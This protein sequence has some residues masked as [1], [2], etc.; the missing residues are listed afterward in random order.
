MSSQPVYK[1]L[2]IF[3]LAVVWLWLERWRMQLG[4]AWED[5]YHHWLLAAHIART[6]MA[7]DP[8]TGNSN[9]WLP[10]YHWTGAGVLSLFGW[11]NLEALGGFSAFLTLLTAAL[12]AWKRGNVWAALFLFNPVTVLNGS[13]S[14]VEPLA[15]LLAVAGVILWEAEIAW[16]AALCWALVALCDRGSWPEVAV[17][18]LWFLPKPIA[19]LPMLALALGYGLTHQEV[20]TTAVWAAVDQ[21]GL[22]TISER[23]ANLLNFSWK[24]LAIALGL[25]GLGLWKRPDLRTATLVCAGLTAVFVLVSA[26]NLTGSSRYYLLPIALLAF[27][28]GGGRPWVGWLLLPCLGFFSVQYLELWPQWVVLNRPSVQA[29]MWLRDK[30]GILAT[31]SPVVAYISAWLPEKIQGT[32]KIERADFIATIVDPRYQKLYPLLVQHPE[33]LVGKPLPGWRVGLDA[34][35]WTIKYGAKPIRIYEK[36][37]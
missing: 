18:V 26:G 13:L 2:P 3:G 1:A 27:L 30:T 23:L 24:P 28:S 10:L 5:S 17:A 8:I 20:A 29:G 6:G 22:G 9:G 25:A 11:H 31:D 15:A 14:V 4:I 12:I 32:A 7:F 19:L 16:G 36:M 34:E 35:D 21:Q 37:H 33:I